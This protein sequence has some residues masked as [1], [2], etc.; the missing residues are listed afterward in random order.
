MLHALRLAA[1][2][3]LLT[4][5]PALAQTPSLPDWVA[6]LREGGEVIVLR[7][8]A[9]HVDQVDAKP[10]DPTDIVHQ[11]QLS[12]EGR[13]SARVIGAVLRELRVP[14]SEVQTS[15]YHRAAETGTLLGL[16][17]V[18]STDVLTEGGMESG[19]QGVALRKLAATPRPPART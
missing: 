19:R 10:F 1:V 13:A 12:D 16:G 5:L 3:V 6:Q 14:V 2:A 7:H 4:T 9:T 11:R 8:V 18:N 15:L 17:K